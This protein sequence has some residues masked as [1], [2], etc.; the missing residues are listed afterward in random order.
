MAFSIREKGDA[1]PYT[2]TLFINGAPSSMVAT[3]PDGSVSTGIVVTGSVALNPLDL[4]SVQV[5][6]FGGALNNGVC[7]SLTT[8]F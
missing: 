7:I 4:V 6:W 8:F 2:A 5:T 3:I 1:T